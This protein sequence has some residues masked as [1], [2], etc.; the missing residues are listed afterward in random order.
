MMNCNLVLLAQYARSMSLPV[1]STLNPTFPLSS[2]LEEP[3]APGLR[4]T[5]SYRVIHSNVNIDHEMV[6]RESDT[7]KLSRQDGSIPRGDNLGW[8]DATEQ[9]GFGQEDKAISELPHLADQRFRVQGA[10]PC[11]FNEQE[12]DTGSLSSM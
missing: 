11:L 8:N 4:R 7:F 5:E 9:A 1:P 3:T 2:G 12:T 10:D 6:Q